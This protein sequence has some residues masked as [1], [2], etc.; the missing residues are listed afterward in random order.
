MH[1][2]KEHPSDLPLFDKFNAFAVGN[3]VTA[4]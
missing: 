4:A 1:P 3:F 2:I